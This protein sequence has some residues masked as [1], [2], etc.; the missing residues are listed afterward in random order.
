M[1]LPDKDGSRVK[2]GEGI[3]LGTVYHMLTEY[4]PATVQI[5]LYA[6]YQ[7]TGVQDGLLGIFVNLGST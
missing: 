5:R 2:S 6:E 1:C 3:N 4:L 7:N